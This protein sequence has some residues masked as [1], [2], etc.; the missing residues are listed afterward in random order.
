MDSV[1]RIVKMI[2]MSV[3]LIHARMEQLAKIMSIHTHVPALLDFLEDTAKLMTTI[4][5]LPLA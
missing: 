4:A 5:Q 3:S 2:L 1:A